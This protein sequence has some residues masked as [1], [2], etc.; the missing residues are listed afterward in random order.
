MPRAREPGWILAVRD[1]PS[2]RRGIWYRLTPDGIELCSG[3]EGDDHHV[4]LVATARAARELADLL[5]H[6]RDPGICYP[7]EEAAELSLDE[8]RAA[9][10]RED[11]APR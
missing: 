3:R 7:E 8:T 1:D 9:L 6:G 5:E 10:A 4:Q 2:N 11:P